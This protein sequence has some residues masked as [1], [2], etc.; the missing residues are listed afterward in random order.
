MKK[1]TFISLFLFCFALLHSQTKTIDS[2]LLVLKQSKNDI[3]K[4]QNLNAMANE[5]KTNDPKLMMDYATKALQLSQKIQYK[6]EEG[7]A[8]LN[9]G[10][11]NIILGNYSEALRYFA[12]ANQY[13]DPD[14]S[15]FTGTDDN[16]ARFNNFVAL[17]PKNAL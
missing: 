14:V 7:Y 4:V 13:M 17:Y 2:L 9:L 15:L 1:S 10:N 11:A 5:Y 3:D 8:D 6:I 16:A 12:S